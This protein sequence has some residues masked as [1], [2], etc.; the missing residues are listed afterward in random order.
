MLKNEQIR[1]NEILFC[2]LFKDLINKN[3]NPV[4]VI[5]FMTSLSEVTGGNR[6]VMNSIITIIFNNDKRYMATKQEYV[7]LLRKT[8]LTVRQ[9]IKLT[10]VSYSTF[11]AKD[12]VEMH[13]EPKFDEAQ[14]K[15][16]MNV[17]KFFIDTKEMIDGGELK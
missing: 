17:F 7:Y 2:N 3:S 5:D 9:I 16:M 13:I 12:Q 10:H 1:L 15:E 8:N 4:K 6:L 11:Y 14:Y